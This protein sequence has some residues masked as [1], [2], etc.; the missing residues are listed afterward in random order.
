MRC[1]FLVHDFD[2]SIAEGRSTEYHM[3]RRF[4]TIGF[5]FR[6]RMHS[7]LV[8]FSFLAT[9]YCHK[10]KFDTFIHIKLYLATDMQIWSWDNSETPVYSLSDGLKYCR[11]LAWHP[12]G[13]CG[14]GGTD[15]TRTVPGKTWI[16]WSVLVL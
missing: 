2:F 8:H 13:K 1:F 7:G 15:A 4:E 10:R 14:D 9:T 12:I 3:E 11:S 5:L 16:A 6:E